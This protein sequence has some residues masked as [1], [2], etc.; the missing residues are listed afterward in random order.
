VRRD[1]A[2]DE[3]VGVHRLTAVAEH[4]ASGEL[5]AFTDL[6]MDDDRPS[7]AFQGYTFVLAAH[8]GHRLGML[9]KTAALDGLARFYPAVDHIQTGNAD[10]NSYMLN[11]NI[12]LGYKLAAVGAELQKKTPSP[13]AT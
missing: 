1:F 13:A 10:E 6:Y 7:R 8:R 12:A 3:A 4:I 5:V 2:A 11:I 9:V